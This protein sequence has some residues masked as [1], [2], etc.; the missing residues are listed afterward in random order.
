V[1]GIIVVLL[2][3][4]PVCGQEMQPRAYLPS[5][6]GVGF[7]GISYS[8]SSGD[9]LFDPSLPV[10]DG[11]ISAH[12]PTLSLGGVFSTFGRTT[13]V[14]AVM[15]YAFADLSGRLEGQPQYRYRS[16]LT[17]MSFRC[18]INLRGAPAMTRRQFAEYQQ[19]TI[20]GVS[21]TVSA[22][23]GQYDPK[24]LINIGTN[25]WAFK[26]EVGM[27]R[28]FARKW[29]V[30]GAFGAWLYTR[31]P[32]F[33]DNLERTQRPLWSTQAHVVRVFNR[34]HWLAY[35]LTYFAGGAALVNGQVAATY[36]SNIRMG[37]TYG[38]LF[39]PRQ[40]IRFSYFNGVTTRIGSDTSAVGVAYQ[41]LWATGR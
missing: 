34:R 18:A 16:G 31:N 37:G 41:F 11:H 22:P 21:L 8:Y 10:E 1:L 7:A 28:A 24:K 12:L 9:L 40:A 4:G 2:W 26:P 6:I 32:R 19:K 30:E 23:T 29:A 17:D 36:Q 39:T 14:L 35:D 15:P 27:S 33:N 3:P 13:Q 5:P 38:F 25:R 20:I